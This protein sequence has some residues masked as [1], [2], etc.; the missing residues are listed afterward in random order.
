MK[1]NRA[2]LV[3]AM[4]LSSL[5]LLCLPSCYTLS[6]IAIDPNTKTFNVV[7]FENNS[8]NVVP[9]LATDFTEALKN[10][11][12][13]E[14]RLNLRT[15][16]PDIEFSGAITKYAVTAEAPEPGETVSFNRLTMTVKVDFKNYNDEDNVWSKTFE[17]FD[18]FESNENLISI[19]D[20]LIETLN[21][22]LVD[23]IFNHAF[24][25][26]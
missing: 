11:I 25:N 7:L 9:T 20:G 22:N 1:I 18:N 14:S 26:W 12:R 10:K 15:V 5:A 8:L 6:G 23:Q 17:F 16:D 13:S 21:E 19:Q 3:K 4:L 2:S 24:T